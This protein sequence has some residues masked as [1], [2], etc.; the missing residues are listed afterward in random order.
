MDFVTTLTIFASILGLAG[1]IGAAFGRVAGSDTA[2]PDRPAGRHFNGVFTGVV[3]VVVLGAQYLLAPASSILTFIP[4]VPF[5]RSTLQGCHVTLADLPHGPPL[6]AA[7]PPQQPSLTGQSLEI[8]G[9]SVLYRLF[10]NAAIN[11]VSINNVDITVEK[12]DSTQGLR[13]LLAGRA[14]IALSDVFA[15]D[16]PDPTIQAS[17]GFLD[18]QVAVSPFTMLVSSDLSATV[19]NLTTQ[20][21]IDI[22]SG[23]ITNWRTIGGPDEQITVFNRRLGSGTR[24]NFEKYVIGISIPNDD[25]RAPT[26][27]GLIALLAKTRGGIGYAATSAVLNANPNTV[28][29]VCIDGYAPTTRNI[30]AST[31]QF[32]SYEHAYTRATTGLVKAFLGYVCSEDFQSK[33]VIGA[34]FLPLSHLSEQAIT[35]HAEDYPAPQACEPAAIS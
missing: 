32:W 21:I 7:L 26:T 12:L 18:Y 15:L 27:Q 6:H 14:Q 9:S 34:G 3:L 1:V 8:S 24:V 11:F 10:A 2:K 17:T 31:Y 29:P 33:D 28:S 23:K 19:Q 16:D 13:D 22:Y 5:P 25:L 4:G 35:S 20:Q 30:E